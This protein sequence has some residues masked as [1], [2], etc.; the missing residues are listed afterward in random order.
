[1]NQE[2]NRT[3]QSNSEFSGF[4]MVALL[5]KHKWYIIVATVLVA[6]ASVIYSLSLPNWY[7]ASVSVVPPKSAGN[8]LEQAMGGL[9]FTCIK[10]SR[11]V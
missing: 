8:M 3:P 2:T 4:L 1:M 6:V 5:F 7:S 10:R 11:F 9:G